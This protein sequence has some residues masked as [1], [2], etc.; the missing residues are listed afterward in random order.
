MKAVARADG[1]EVAQL[2]GVV[3]VGALGPERR[4]LGPNTAVANAI[5]QATG[6]KVLNWHRH[7]LE[8]VPWRQVWTERVEAVEWAPL[9]NKPWMILIWLLPGLLG[10]FLRR[11]W[12][13][14]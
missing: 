2:E 5:S 13:L 7:D 10:I 14:A 6:G 9:W 4:Q 11:R 1:A 12:N 8:D 3:L